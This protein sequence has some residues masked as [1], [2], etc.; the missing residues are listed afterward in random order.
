[1]ANIESVV[2]NK[3]CIQ[4]G[5]CA[6]ACPLR[7]IAMRRKGNDFLPGI[8]AS[9]CTNCGICSRI[10]AVDD[11]RNYDPSVPLDD[12]I[13]GSYS[14]IYCAQ[15]KNADILHNAASGGV[16]TTLIDALLRDNEYD[17]AF[18][19]RGYNYDDQLCTT[20]I[21]AGD[22]LTDTP[23]SRYLTV[24]HC[25]AA[26]YIREN[27]DRRVILIGTGCII[28]SFLNTIRT[29]NLNRDNYFLIG[30]FCDKTMNYGVNTYFAEHRVNQGRRMQNLHFRTKDAGGWP[31]NVMLHYTDGT[32]TALHRTERMKLKDYFIPE[33]CL[34][35]LNKLNRNAD[36]S[37]GDN[38][39][40]DNADARGISSVVIRTDTGKHIWQ[41]YGDLFIY[42]ADDAEKL[43]RS[44]SLAQKAKNL[45]FAGIKGL[46]QTPVTPG[47]RRDYKRAMHKIKVGRRTD[48]YNAINDDLRNRGPFGK[49][50]QWLFSVNNKYIRGTKTKVLTIFGLK[51]KLRTTGGQ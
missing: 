42:S 51:L 4:C 48:V 27:P 43:K 36:I 17:C 34:Y 30:L 26:R 10:C 3:L 33:K 8:D 19:I 23:K 49:F 32:S 20:K 5:M 31:G 45:A 12:F 39:I 22:N 7:C 16:A 6:A 1:M 24:S 18:V 44:Q 11:L 37:V 41:K 14:D 25:A 13:L 46:I 47:D 38:Y 15:T 2:K 29:F 28:T 50:A 9:R 35:C 21:V 40:A